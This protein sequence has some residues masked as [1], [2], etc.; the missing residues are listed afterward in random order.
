PFRAATPL[1]TLE[2]VC[3]QEPVAPVQL[4]GRTPRDLS[5]ICLKCLEKDPSR[6]YASAQDLAEDLRRFLQGEVI[7]AR[8]VRAVERVWRWCRRKPGLAALLASAITL[9]VVTVV[10]SAVSAWRLGVEADRARRAERD[11]TEK[12]F[13]S[14]L[15][16]AQ[17][18]R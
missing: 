11:A 2:Q 6:R 9:A 7:R 1:E 4:Q 12:L 10:V 13:K 15:T 16:R 18:L 8:P 3:T 5:T 14:T 17:A